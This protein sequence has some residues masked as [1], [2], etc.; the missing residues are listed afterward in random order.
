MSMEFKIASRIEGVQGSIIREIFKLTADPSIIAFGGGNPN[1]ATFPVDEIARITA[2]VFRSNPVSVLQYGMSEG[3]TPLRET[4]KSYLSKHEGLNFDKNELFIVSGAQQAAD[5]VTKVLV[6]EGDVILTEDPSFVGC[7]NTFR[8]YGAKLVGIPMEADGLNIEKLEEALKTYKNIRFLYTIPS[9][10]NP[11]GFTTSAEK[12]KKIYELAHQYEIAIFEDNPYGELRF[13]G[14]TVP[15]IKSLDTDGRVIYAGSFSKVMAPA[16]RLGFMVFDKALTSRITVAKQ[17]TDVHS[18]VLFQH[19]CNE[20][21]TKCDYAGHIQATRELYRNKSKL[22]LDEMEKSFHP[23]VA[24]NRPEGGLFVMAFL[25]EGYDSFPFVHEGIKRGVACVPGVAFA[26]DQS[27]PSNGFRL[28]F[29]M[30]SDENI[31]RGVQILG[32]LT[33]EWLAR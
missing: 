11:T 3:Y 6:N 16:F 21:M 23:D 5:L 24:F 4:L 9:F 14:E 18:T 8:S 30:P 12:R 15:T 1:P 29:S 33:H 25:P 28:N 22:M 2:D 10:Q 7:L 13:A 26:I 19:I 27:Q 17:V 20:Y 32:Q 31:V